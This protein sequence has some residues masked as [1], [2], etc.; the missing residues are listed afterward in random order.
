MERFLQHLADLEKADGDDCGFGMEFTSMKRSLASVSDQS[1]LSTEAGS[2]RSNMKKNR[3]KDILP[4]DQ[5]RV[6]LTLLLQ[7]G[8]SDYINA[9]FI[10][11]IGGE[12][13]YIA[14]QGPLGQTVTDLWR[15]I[16]EY[17]VKVVVMA[18]REFELGKRKCERYWA[19]KE[20]GTVVFGPFTVTHVGEESL[21]DEVSIRTLSV[22]MLDEVDV[23]TVVQFQYTAWP[24][25]GIPKDF[26]SLLEMIDLMHKHQGALSSPIC[27]HC[28][29]GC[30]RTGVICAV[31]YVRCMI[32]RKS[33]QLKEGKMGLP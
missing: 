13:Y 16:W 33:H 28:S 5:T 20:E 2:A 7:E 31:D 17:H 18:C 12:K 26:D 1:E 25:H 15:M 14:T 9:N 11:G 30:G 10:R 4:Y 22:T 3:Y 8:Y 32:Q 27:V 6:P 24:D 21:R 23:R 19:T 29:A